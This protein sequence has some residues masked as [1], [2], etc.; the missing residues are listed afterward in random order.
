MSTTATT[1]TTPRTRG[2]ARTWFTVLAA[3]AW[4]GLALEVVVT[5][6]GMY[7]SLVTTPSLWGYDNPDALSRL[8]DLASYFTIWSNAVVAVVATVLARHP[9][10]D[11]R[12][13]RAVHLS[14]LVMISV[15]GLVYGVILAGLSQQRG[16]EHLTNFFVHQSTPVLALVVFVV[17][18]PRGWID[19]VTIVRSLVIPFVWLGYCLVRGAVIHSYPY[20]FLDVVHL[21]YGRV[22]LDVV[23]VVVL[24]LVIA[25]VLLVVDRAL[26]R[27]AASRAV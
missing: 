4:L 18:G 15:T 11:S 20:F 7:P 26:V 9:G 19:G 1:G 17:V 25:G 3:W 13:L 10:R 6:S 12:W 21:G 8:V 14:G 24:A 22:L 23:G 27:R 5:G 2:S 16:W